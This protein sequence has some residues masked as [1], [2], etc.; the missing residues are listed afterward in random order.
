[1]RSLKRSRR[2]SF[3]IVTL[4]YILAAA[5]GIAVYGILAFDWWLNLLIADAAATVLTFMFSVFL[6]NASVYDP[7]WSVQPIVILVAFAAGKELT[8]V[9]VLLLTA[10]I[11]WGVRLTANWA[12]TFHGL[13]HQ[14]WRYTMLKEK[15]GVF[16]PLINFA[17]IHMVPTLVVY[18]CTL[19]AVYAF[20]QDGAWNAGSVL[21]FGISVAAA[22]MQ[23][24]ADCQ[25]HRFRRNRNGVF[26][27]EGLWKYSRHPNYLGEIIMWWGVAL[28]VI[29]VFPNV[30]YLGVGALANTV[31]FFAVSIPMAD[32]K[33]SLKPGFEEYKRET[34]M[35]LPL[36]K[37]QGAS[38]TQER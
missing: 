5:V 24:I 35:L 14:D 10:V 1:M 6:G 20:L 3:V 21:F 26:I 2:A 31:L 22:V 8:P 16:Y 27:R 32:G 4:I 38:R 36:K 28:S 17:G 13:M 19:P 9:R 34:N 15:T 12:Y 18:G 30:W 11:F 33:Q 25:M 29:S 37:Q 23:G 7:Y